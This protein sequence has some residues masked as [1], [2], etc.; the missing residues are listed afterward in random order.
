VEGTEDALVGD[1]IGERVRAGLLV[2]FLGDLR[3]LLN[4]LF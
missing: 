3:T 2:E 1:L 4:T